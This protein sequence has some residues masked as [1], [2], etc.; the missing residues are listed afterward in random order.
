MGEGGP[1]W[2]PGVRKWLLKL[3]NDEDCGSPALLLAGRCF[4]VQL[5]SDIFFPP[6]L[7]KNSEIAI[8]ACFNSFFFFKLYVLILFLCCI[9]QYNFIIDMT[10]LANKVVPSWF[11]VETLMVSQKAPHE[12]Q[13]PLP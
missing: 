2:V 13:E 3:R 9:S 4:A 1:G 7:Q 6:K 12:S 8:H 10:F 5:N 11:L